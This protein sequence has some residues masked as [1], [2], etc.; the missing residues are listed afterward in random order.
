M[1]IHS[2]DSF[3]SYYERVRERTLW[4]VELVPPE[5]MEWVYLPGKFSIADSIRHIAAI[6]RLLYAEIV[7]GKPSCYDGCGAHL[8]AGYDDV[9]AY[10]QQMHEETVAILRELTDEDLQRKCATPGGGEIR[11][12]KWLRAMVEHE[13][14]HRAQLY[15]YLNML[16]VRT[17]PM[18]GLTEEQLKEMILR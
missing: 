5:R 8:A 6:E 10:F 9:L 15:L 4:V 12:W 17:P 1:E 2:I 14:H 16:G 11:V 3:L 13:I 7:Q 18:F